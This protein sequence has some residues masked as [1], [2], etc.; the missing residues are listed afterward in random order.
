MVMFTNGFTTD[1]KQTTGPLKE[2]VVHL[3]PHDGVLS[4]TVLLQ[5]CL[6]LATWR[7]QPVVLHDLLCLVLNSLYVLSTKLLQSASS[8]L[9]HQIQLTISEFPEKLLLN[10]LTG[11]L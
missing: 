1:T 2:T 10:K 3:L 9:Y 6:L 11:H 8:I 7:N 5:W 4:W